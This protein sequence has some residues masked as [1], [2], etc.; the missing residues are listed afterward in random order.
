MFV[1]TDIT[2]NLQRAERTLTDCLGIA[3]DGP[4]P[5][6]A[7]GMDLGSAPTDKRKSAK[8]SKGTWDLRTHIS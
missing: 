3:G 5:C 2:R 8:D 1:S 7:A 4:K 6:A